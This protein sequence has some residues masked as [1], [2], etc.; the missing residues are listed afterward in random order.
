[1]SLHVY[2]S[3]HAQHDDNYDLRFLDVG[4]DVSVVLGDARLLRWNLDGDNDFGAD[5]DV[6][7]FLDV[8]AA[9]LEAGAFFFCVVGCSSSSS[10]SSSSSASLWLSAVWFVVS[11]AV[12]SASFPA[13]ACFTKRAAAPLSTR[14]VGGC[15]G[16]AGVDVVVD[17]F[18]ASLIFWM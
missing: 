1:M 12:L 17:V 15:G 8:D 6:G 16:A 2:Q 5:F 18:C 11:V 13:N 4:C 10:S 7:V 14:C 9:A 3:S